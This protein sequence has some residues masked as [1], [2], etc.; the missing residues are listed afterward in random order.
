ML[1]SSWERVVFAARMVVMR[2]GVADI[3]A[4]SVAG[5]IAR[6]LAEH[7]ECELVVQRPGCDGWVVE[8]PW[9]LLLHG[10]EGYMV[11]PF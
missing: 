6:G 3:I 1:I 7:V 2:L 8:P 4:G 9:E 10:W 5:K 11:T